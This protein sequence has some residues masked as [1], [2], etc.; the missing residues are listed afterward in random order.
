MQ[1]IPDHIIDRIR[2]SVDIVEVVSRYISL[3]KQGKNY[4]SSC[5]FHTEKTPSFT[6]SP[7]KQIFYCFGCGAG[8][9]V[10]N[11][12]MRY[13][14]VTFIEAVQKLAAETGIELPKYKVDEQQVSEYEKLYRAHQF[15]ADEYH[16]YL[17]DHFAEIKEYLN[18]RGVQQ[19]TIDFFKMGYVPNEWDYLYNRIIKEKMSLEPFIQSGLI[20]TS[21]KESQKKYDRF[22]QRIIFPIH[23][24]SG[25]IVA[26]GGRTLSADPNSPK[27]LNS[28]ESPIYNKSQILYGLYFS[29]DWIRQEE[30]AIFVEGY[31]DFIQ[32]F[33]NG[34]KNIVATSGTA[35][36]EEHAKLIKRYTR[37]IVLCYDSDEA[38]I[39]AALRGGQILF[40]NDLEVRVL[41]L[42]ENEDPDSYVQKNG[43]SA[44]YA[45][46]NEAN[47]YFHFKNEY[48]E[49]TLKGT[50]ISKRSKVVDELI[51]TL[52]N[53]Q[54]PV[55]QNMY[56]N[57]LAQRY[58]LQE[59]TLMEEIRK[60]QKIFKSRERRTR[61][62]DQPDTSPLEKIK[63]M[64]GA[65]SAEKDIIILLLKHYKE[66]KN[67]IF[68]LVEAQDF[69][70]DDF[71]RTYQFIKENPGTDDQ[72]LLHHILALDIDEHSLSLLTGDIFK[73]IENPDKYLN[74]CIKKL[75]LTRYQRDIDILRS[76]LKTM[77]PQD[78]DYQS[79]LQKMN[80]SLRQIQELRKV[81]DAK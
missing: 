73:D 11:F 10:F 52:V 12:L 25:R 51:A 39:N 18:K 56:V 68:N 59:N 8:G 78:A 14:K 16:K 67:I 75:K 3:K 4:K 1:K 76:N 6:V 41:I 22:R 60:R 36:T 35:L 65:W 5:P 2:D 57:I 45:L 79:T 64:T 13:E 32:L 50:D 61:T 44:F 54:D 20:L 23:N 28:P 29:K 30:S 48:L 70:N 43:S 69:L 31:M 58:G 26:F 80:D 27:Y 72:E 19:K 77:S 38:G 81:F 46:L 40:E 49:N 71:R 9:N 7:D 24:L 62:P 63:P 74:D 37:N 33:Q 53:H 42:P 55:K 15:A 34:I 47:E 21:E 17:K 66:V